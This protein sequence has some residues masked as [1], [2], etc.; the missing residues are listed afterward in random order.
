MRNNRL[1][2]EYWFV[3]GGRIQK[4]ENIG[5]VFLRLTEHELGNATKLVDSTFFGSYEHFYQDHVFGNKHS[6]HYVVLA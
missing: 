4:D 6:T 2:Q 5:S 1:A 3:S